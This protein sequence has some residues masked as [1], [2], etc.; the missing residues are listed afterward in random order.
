[1]TADIAICALRN[2]TPTVL[3]VFNRKCK[4]VERLNGFHAVIL[5]LDKMDE[6]F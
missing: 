3:K 4:E 5:K 1:M 2:L 6:V